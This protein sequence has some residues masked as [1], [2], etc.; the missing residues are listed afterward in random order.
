MS[1]LA[2]AS[3]RFATTRWSVVRSCSDAKESTN[4]LARQ[5]LG[6]LC[7]IYWRPI[8][9]YICL[10]GYSPEDAEDLTQDFFA[11]VLEGSLLERADPGRGRFR[12]LLL[13]ALGNFLNDATDRRRSRKRGGDIKFISWDDWV[14]E[15]SQ[16]I[17]L[18]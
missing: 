14:A 2:P 16:E 9:A 7:Q 13:R 8:F 5:A 4:P 11:A 12:S 6:Q 17:N 15:S 3:D 10:R 18:M 1:T